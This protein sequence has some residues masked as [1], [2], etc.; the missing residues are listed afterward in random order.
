MNTSAQRLADKTA[1]DVFNDLTSR[2]SAHEI[3]RG[4]TPGPHTDVYVAC[5]QDA[6]TNLLQG[7]FTVADWG[8][9]S[10]T[11]A[12]AA[13]QKKKPPTHK[14]SPTAV[15]TL[16]QWNNL[17]IAI[18]R[19]WELTPDTTLVA[20]L[21]NI[22]PQMTDFLFARTN[23]EPEIQTNN[24][25]GIYLNHLIKE[26]GR[27][28][29]D[30]HSTGDDIN[31]MLQDF[32]VS[33]DTVHYTRTKAQLQLHNQVKLETLYEAHQAG[34]STTGNPPKPRPTKNGD[35]ETGKRLPCYHH[36]STVG[37]K[38]SRCQ[39]SHAKLSAPQLDALK[40]GIEGAN[41]RHS[42][43]TPLVLDPAKTKA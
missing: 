37:C 6:A 34:T 3:S 12:A 35:K 5:G 40:K 8:P 39:F 9:V 23:P 17:V 31:Q 7:I 13:A 16:K 29:G 25:C 10:H 20:A 2:L 26:F 33:E 24:F 15:D 18:T 43:K 11:E 21:W 36:F 14:T 1:S 41:T 4:R 32:R 22:H 28:M 19:A 38:A 42:D 30:Y 27:V